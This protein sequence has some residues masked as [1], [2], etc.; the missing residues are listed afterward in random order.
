MTDAGGEVGRGA[1]SY[2]IMLIIPGRTLCILKERKTSWGQRHQQ[3][4]IMKEPS[5]PLT[6]ATLED[7]LSQD[8]RPLTS[9]ATLPQLPHTPPPRGSMDSLF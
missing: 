6:S 8:S 2:R 3:L 7:C 9:L 5:L 1:T 4:M